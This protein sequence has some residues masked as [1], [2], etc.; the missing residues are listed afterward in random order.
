M[1]ECLDFIRDIS[2][3]PELG[4]PS[5]DEAEVRIIGTGKY[6]GGRKLQDCRLLL[7]DW[8]KFLSRYYPR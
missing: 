7:S 8:T 5:G 4:G 1:G 3:F 6:I 2:N